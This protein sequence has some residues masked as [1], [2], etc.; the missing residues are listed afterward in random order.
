MLKRDIGKAYIKQRHKDSHPQCTCRENWCTFRYL[1]WWSNWKCFL[2]FSWIPNS[3][4]RGFTLYVAA[5]VSTS[6]RLALSLCWTQKRSVNHYHRYLMQLLFICVVQCTVK[7]VCFLSKLYLELSCDREISEAAYTYIAYYRLLTEFFLNVK[8]VSELDI[9][10]RSF[11]IAKFRSNSQSK[12]WHFFTRVVR[13]Y[14]QDILF[15][16][17]P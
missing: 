15:S 9:F 3:L 1:S 5:S 10:T 11:R 17:E 6:L 7:A 4:R 14:R 16:C 8:T 12:W 2:I 13:K